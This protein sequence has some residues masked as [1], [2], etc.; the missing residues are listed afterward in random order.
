MT[1]LVQR[2][3]SELDYHQKPLRLVRRDYHTEPTLNVFLFALAVPFR[4]VMR[5]VVD[6]KPVNANIPAALHYLLI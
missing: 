5:L 3:I 6:R 4:C 2:K 1:D